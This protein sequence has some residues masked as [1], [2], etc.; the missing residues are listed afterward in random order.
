MAAPGQLKFSAVVT[1]TQIPIETLNR[2]SDRSLISMR[3]SDVKAG[4]KGHP[5]KFSLARVYQI[6]IAHA[7]TKLSISPSVAMKLAA[8]FEEPQRGRALGKL[9]PLGH[10]L[11]VARADG[12]GE[13]V[14]LAPDGDIQSLFTDDATVVVNLNG[15][16]SRV[17]QRIG[18]SI[19]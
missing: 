1:A 16:L 2:W 9:F 5:R 17:N 6:S 3:G 15:I 19:Q 14:Q 10:T 7:L 8:K 12:T 18:S 13:I 11:L 4:G